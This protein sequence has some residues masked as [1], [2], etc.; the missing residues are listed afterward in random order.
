MQA[1]KNTESKRRFSA[2]YHRTSRNAERIKKKINEEE[3]KEL[4]R[5]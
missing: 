4:M 2:C 1:N 5:A 3:E